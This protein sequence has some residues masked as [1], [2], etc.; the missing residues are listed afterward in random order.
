MTIDRSELSAY[1]DGELTPSRAAEV[2]RAAREDPDLQNEL[3]ELQRA[4]GAWRAAAQAAMFFP[5]VRLP[6]GTASSRSWIPLATAVIPLVVLRFVPEDF[7]S[8]AWRLAVHSALLALVLVWAVRII[9]VP[10]R[11]PRSYE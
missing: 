9:A 3:E 10:E 2:E 4:E 8:L 11:Y 6:T 7:A 5:V 1:V